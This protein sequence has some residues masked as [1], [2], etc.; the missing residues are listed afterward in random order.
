LFHPKPALISETDNRCCLP[1]PDADYAHH[2]ARVASR[3][4]VREKHIRLAAGAP[5]HQVDRAWSHTGIEQ[6]P[7]IG[8][9]QI[10]MQI[11]ADRRVPW[12]PLGQKEHGVLCPNRIGVINVAK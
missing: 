11:W 3:G 4:T 1:G 12:R 6:L 9:N 2:A 10:E 5:S 8:F 7:P